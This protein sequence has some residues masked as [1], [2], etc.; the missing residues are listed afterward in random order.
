MDSIYL[1]S[2]SKLQ[3]RQSWRY[4]NLDSMR[5]TSTGLIICTFK[6][7]LLALHWMNH[8]GNRFAY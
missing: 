2:L 5:N 7:I 1:N 4:Q 8:S 3:S 6:L